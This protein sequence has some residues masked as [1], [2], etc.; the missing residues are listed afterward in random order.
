MA[1]GSGKAVAAFGSVNIDVTGFCYRLPRAGETVPGSRSTTTLGGKGANQAAAAARLGDAS[2]MIGRIGADAFG[3][4]ARERLSAL[5]V[6]SAYLLSTS[7]V[8]TGMAL[9]TVDA[10]AENCIVVNG[11]ANARVDQ[12]VVD[13]AAVPLRAASALLLQLEVPLG[14]SLAAAALTR[15]GGGLVI[16]DPAPAPREGLPQAAYAAIDIITPNETET[17]ALVGIRPESAAD[18]A[19]AAAVLASRGAPTAIIKMGARGAFYRSPQGEGFVPPFAV[20]AVNSVGAG[21]C[22]NG[23]LAVALGRGD[24]LPEAVRFAAACGALATTGPG[25]AE[26]APTLAAARDLLARSPSL[27]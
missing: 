27:A 22:F 5:A 10:K 14:P 2:L 15:A 20:R 8:A 16:F 13:N 1:G 26:A 21:D 18:A 25:G 7:G 4:L 12:S 17:E 3:A 6:D 11:G 23:A 24:P 9:I 19:R